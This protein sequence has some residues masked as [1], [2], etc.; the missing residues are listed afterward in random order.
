MSTINRMKKILS[1]D[2]NSDT[3]DFGN[4]DV[5]RTTT[6]KKTWIAYID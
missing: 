4:G 3:V 1:S 2:E 6:L 5:K